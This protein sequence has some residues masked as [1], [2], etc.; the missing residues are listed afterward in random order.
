MTTNPK[1]LLT[2]VYR[3]FANDYYDYWGANATT[4]FRPSLLRHISYGLRFLKQ[5]V[6]EVEIIEYPT[7]HEYLK[8][9]QEGWDVVGFSFYLNEVHEIIAMAD[10][11]R[12]AGV[13]ELWAGNYGAL[14]DGMENHFD[15]IFIGPAEET[16]AAIFD[17]KLDRLRHPPLVVALRLGPFWTRYRIAGMLFTSRSCPYK[18]DFCQTPAFSPK[19]QRIPLESIDEVLRYYQSINCHHVTILDE[20]FGMFLD[21]SDKVFELLA[22]Y[23]M[24]A[25]VMLRADRL[26]QRLTPWVKN[27]MEAGFIGVESLSQATLDAVGKRESTGIIREAVAKMHEH[28]CYTLGYYMIGFENETEATIRENVKELAGYGI[29]FHQVCVVTPLPKTPLWYE[30]DKKYGIFERDYRKY[31]LKHSVFNHPHIKPLEMEELLRWSFNTLNTPSHYFGSIKR[32]IG[33]YVEGEGALKAW[34]HLLS[35]PVKAQ[36]YDDRDRH[37]RR[38]L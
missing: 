34:Y 24:Y 37:R 13:K 36:F 10:A 7:W 19:P 27:G 32:L 17:R 31:D 1:I 26:L 20:N 8:K 9:L 33:R 15:R 30:I 5:N 35:V 2:T 18:C 4:R 6:P 12:K 22:R 38:F 3:R 23:K 29:D 16:L 21:H 25:S 14:T 11:A 28:N